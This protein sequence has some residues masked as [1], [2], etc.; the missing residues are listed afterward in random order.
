MGRIVLFKCRSCNG[1]IAFLPTAVGSA[2]CPHCKEEMPVRVDDSLV[3]DGIVRQC[4]AW[5]HDSVYVQKDFNRNLGVA[6]V[7]IGVATSIYFFAQNEPF[8]AMASLFGMAIVDLV[9][10]SLAGE[11][12]VC[13]SCHAV[14]RGFVRNPEH[15][16]FDLKNLEKYGGRDPR[17]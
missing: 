16:S 12:A 11:V 15:E 4:I 6:I 1:E 14:Y 13:Y 10:Y 3:R 9:I 17:F 8:Y 7:V 2:P 5:G